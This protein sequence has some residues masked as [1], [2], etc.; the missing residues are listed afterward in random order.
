M[1]EGTKMNIDWKSRITNKTFWVA[2]VSA[3]VLLTQQLGYNI[4]PSNW[5][6][7][8]NTVLAIFILLGIIIDP[9]T[10]GF[11]DEVKQIVQVA[12]NKQEVKEVK[13]ESVVANN[14]TTK[15]IETSASSKITVDNPDN[16]Q[17]IGNTVN[18]IS[19]NMPQ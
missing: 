6:D 1:K 9:S 2:I 16:V 5:A 8:L 19:A 7:I 14:T 13:A 12:E 10:K 3:I 11:S 18:H 17:A 4:F 15:P